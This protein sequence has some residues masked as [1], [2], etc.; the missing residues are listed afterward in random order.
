MRGM[1]RPSLPH[2]IPKGSVA[3]AWPNAFDASSEL[4]FLGR[5][6]QITL[7]HSWRS[8]VPSRNPRSQLLPCQGK[9][10]ATARAHA[11]LCVERI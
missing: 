10:A 3:S 2:G 9:H 7:D 6:S 1:C 5:G 11:G 4:A 8:A